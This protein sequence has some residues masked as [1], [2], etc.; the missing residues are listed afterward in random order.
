MKSDLIERLH[1]LQWRGTDASNQ[2]AMLITKFIS[3]TPTLLD[4]ARHSGAERNHLPGPLS[5]FLAHR[6]SK[7][8][9]GCFILELWGLLYFHC[10]CNR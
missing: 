8:N 1:R 5:T 6:S 9:N 10:N 4:K 3:K 7:F 2:L